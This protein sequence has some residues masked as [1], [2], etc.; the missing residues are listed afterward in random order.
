MVWEAHHWDGLLA[1]DIGIHPG[2]AVGS[3]ERASFYRAQALATIGGVAQRLDNPRGGIAVMLH[4]DDGRTYYYAHLSSSRIVEDERRRVAAGAPLGRIGNTGTWSQFL[5]PHLHLSIAEGHQE[6]TSWVADV[7]PVWWLE[8]TFG[9]AANGPL[10]RARAARPEQTIYPS[11]PPVGL[12]L[13]GRP[14]ITADFA[15]TAAQNPLLAGLRLAPA[16]ASG[17]DGAGGSFPVRATLTGAVRIHRDTRLGVRLQITNP[18]AGYSVI[19]SGQITSTVEH[20]QL[21]YEDDV[22]GMTAGELHYTVF[23]N[24]RL[25][26]KFEF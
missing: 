1:V 24:G 26:E 15:A 3:P 19:I 7:N 8:R 5:E 17:A 16:G 6:G 9:R 14:V 11:R 4:G 20:G 2:F 22:I 21:V 23:Q 18:K 12:P 25:Q 10:T 13:F